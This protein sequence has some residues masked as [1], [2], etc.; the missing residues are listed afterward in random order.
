VEKLEIYAPA[1]V[2]NCLNQYF[3][4][5]VGRKTM[6]KQRINPQSLKR[7]LKNFLADLSDI[8]FFRQGRRCRYCGGGHCMGLCTQQRQTADDE[9]KPPPPRNGAIAF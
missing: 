2:K 5:P 9:K 3:P 4:T 7:A 6:L 1:I 8:L